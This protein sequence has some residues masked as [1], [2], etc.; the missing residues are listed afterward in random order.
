[1]LYVYGMFRRV[2]IAQSFPV[3]CETIRR[4][5]TPVSYIRRKH[6][7]TRTRTEQI[8]CY[9]FTGCSVHVAWM[10]CCAVWQGCVAVQPTLAGCLAVQSTT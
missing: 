5:V 3:A 2:A 10:V 1:M 8:V 7:D 6:T 9:T 4:N